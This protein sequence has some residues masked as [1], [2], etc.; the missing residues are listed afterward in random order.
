MNAAAF[1]LQRC[2]HVVD[3]ISKCRA[4]QALESSNLQGVVRGG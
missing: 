2:V 1:G 3:P 4:Q